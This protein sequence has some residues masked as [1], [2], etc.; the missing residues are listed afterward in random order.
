M[1]S[2]DL[3]NLYTKIDGHILLVAAYHQDQ[4][5]I[6]LI[7]SSRLKPYT[8]FTG[9]FQPGTRFEKHWVDEFGNS[10]KFED[11]TTRIVLNNTQIS[12]NT[13]VSTDLF[14]GASIK[15]T[16]K[17]SKFALIA[18]GRHFEQDVHLVALYGKDEYLRIFFHKTRWDRISPL[19]LG[20]NTLNEMFKNLGN[21]WITEINKNKLDIQLQFDVDKCITTSLPPRQNITSYF[22]NEIITNNIL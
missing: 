9:D 5:L 17:N 18:N 6:K 22:D 2:T 19:M 3:E 15:E 11:K 16:A 21:P 20:L 7:R 4:N 12:E 1:N 14:F 13:K 8:I 10:L